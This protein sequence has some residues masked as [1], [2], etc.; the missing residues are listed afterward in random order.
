LGTTN[1]LCLLLLNNRNCHYQVIQ[2]KKKYAEIITTILQMNYRRLIHIIL[3]FAALLLIT[4]TEFGDKDRDVEF[5]KPEGYYD[6]FKQITIPLNSK[7]S[8][9]LPNYAVSELKKSIANSPQRLKSATNYPWVQR[10]P[11]NV[12]GRTRCVIIDPDDITGNTWFVGSVSGGIWKTTDAGGSWENLTPDLPNLSTAS[13]AMSAANTSV[14]YAGTGEGYGGEGMVS[15]N[16]IYKSVDKGLSWDS[17]ASIYNDAHFRFVNKLWVSPTNE[18]VVLAATNK[19]IF[20]TTDGGDTWDTVF[21]RGYAVQDIV[22]NPLNE[23]VLYAG[24]NSLGVIKSVKQGDKNSWHSSYNGMGEVYRVSVSVSPV[25]TSYIFAGVEAPDYQ[26]HIYQSRDGGKNWQLNYNTDGQFTNFYKEQ[27][28]FNNVVAAHPFQKSKV[29]VG[30]VYLGLLNFGA[31]TYTSSRDVIRVDTLNTAKFMTF[32]NFGGSYFSGALSTGIDEEAEVDAEDFVSIEIRFDTNLTQKAH[33]FTVPDGEGSGVPADNYYYQDYVDVP[34]QVWDIDNNKQLMVSF[35]DQDT[36][37]VFNLVDRKYGDDISGREYIFINAIDYDS[38]NPSAEIAQT[39]GHEQKLL[40][41]LWP[42]LSDGQTWNEDSLTFATINIKYGSIEYRDAYTTI[43][44]DDKLNK[45]L[46]V[47]HHDM[48]FFIPNPAIENFVIVEAN[49][50]GL[51]LSTDMGTTWQQINKGYLTTQ[52][53]GVA[54]RPGKN[55]Y[56]G[57]MQDNGT[58]QSPIDEAATENS[59]YDFRVEGDGF[60]TL[61]HPWYPQRI[62]ASSYNNLI[63]ISNDFGETWQWVDNSILNDGPF[64]TKLSNSTENPNLVFAVGSAGI[65]RHTNFGLGIASWESIDLGDT[66]AVNNTVT[67]SHN[68]KVSKADP[69]VVWAGGAM[70]KNPDLNIF[71]SKDYGK[72]FDTVSNYTDVEMGYISGMATHP[73]NPAEAFVLFSFKGKPKVLRTMNYGQSWEDLSGFAGSEDGSSNNN[74]PDVVVND[75][76]VMPDTN[77][78]WVATEIGIFESIDNGEWH[79]ANCGL[80]AV[81]IWQ[82]NIVDGQLIVAT[83]GRGIWTADLGLTSTRLVKSEDEF[84]IEVYPNPASDFVKVLINSKDFNSGTL[85]I[86]DLSG[87]QVIAKNIEIDGSEL[88]IDVSFIPRGN[89]ILVLSN[90]THKSFKKLIIK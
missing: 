60:E 90:G 80:P 30:G 48:Q 22:Q 9:Y 63:K 56:I 21:N 27:G 62:L 57:G 88:T 45:E 13:L 3:P 33:R 12:G 39:G 78:I 44:A 4:C 49:D 67:S 76:L 23:H 16:G 36:N 29:F 32:V 35:R 89:Y 65:Y 81:S 66:W 42:S 47:D 50:G 86:I 52:F 72:T 11:G 34:F 14:I 28:W 7:S 55:E 43:L 40:Y 38:L 37:G 25:D 19:G 53:Y 74:F 58:W 6:Y 71:L 15:G 1:G 5:D 17:I 70:F 83:H 64:I 10:G 18:N 2:L 26:T 68:V 46:H 79:Y 77:I 51:G 75:L 73:V 85:K 69:S 54:K 87:K 41:F 24:V 59:D 20:K 31:A 84:D 82:L 61:W 8:G